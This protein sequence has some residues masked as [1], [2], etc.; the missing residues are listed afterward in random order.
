MS[1]QRI[2]R[3]CPLMGKMDTA[4]VYAHMQPAAN[5]F[6]ALKVFECLEEEGHWPANDDVIHKSADQ[7]AGQSK[8]QGLVTQ[9]IEERLEH[10][11]EV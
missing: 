10:Q 1:P 9:P 3:L 7:G 2:D 5:G 11:A 4:L 6:L 8:A